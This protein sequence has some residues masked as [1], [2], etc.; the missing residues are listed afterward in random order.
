MTI[1]LAQHQRSYS[2]IGELSDKD[3]EPDDLDSSF[4][5]GNAPNLKD[6][7]QYDLV[8]VYAY[9]LQLGKEQPE[10]AI[11]SYPEDFFSQK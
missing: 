11:Y 4:Q 5:S 8:D 10:K 3:E 2:S 7:D 6:F 1:K 9:T